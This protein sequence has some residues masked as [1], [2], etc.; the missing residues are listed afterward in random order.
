MPFCPKNWNGRKS[1]SAA[2]VLGFRRIEP[3]FI[4]CLKHQCHSKMEREQVEWPDSL[5][6]CTHHMHA[7]TR[8]L[9][10][11]FIAFF[12]SP[13][14]ITF[15]KS[16]MDLIMVSSCRK[17]RRWMRAEHRYQIVRSS[18]CCWLLKAFWRQQ[19]YNWDGGWH[20]PPGR[21]QQTPPKLPLHPCF[22]P[23]SR[24]KKKTSCERDPIFRAEA[25]DSA[26]RRH[27][28]ERTHLH[29]A[30]GHLLLAQD[31]C[32]FPSYRRLPSQSLSFP[33]QGFEKFNLVA[34]LKISRRSSIM[35]TA[36][37]QWQS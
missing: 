26:P 12:P 24:K 13:F 20:Q 4:H 10:S 34:T 1:T 14:Y 31:R 2:S 32:T 27:K 16:C 6:P 7:L 11:F 33:A 8:V 25:L 9:W 15:S 21:R 3:L 17:V 37:V 28:P 5:H 22:Y 30:V 36:S 19:F 23:F 35:T 29:A 18:S